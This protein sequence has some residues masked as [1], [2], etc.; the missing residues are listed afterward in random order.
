M[1]LT[2]LIENSGPEGLI[3]EHGLSLYFEYRGGNYLLDAGESGAFLVNAGHLGVD[4]SAVDA[5][6][7]S[8]GHFDHAD[9]FGGFFT[10]NDHTSVCARPG[11]KDCGYHGERYIGVNP[12]LLTRR[13]KRFDLAD[14]PR[15]IAPGLHLIPDSV[16]H[17]QSVVAETERGLVV[18]NCC[19]HAGVDKI[20]ADIMERFPGQRIRAI[21]GGFH[22]MG[23]EG[24]SSLGKTEDEVRTLARRLVDELG[25]EAVYTGHCTGTPAFALLRETCPGRFHPL[26]TGLQL[27]F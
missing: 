26:T 10:V 23:K 13:A 7:L 15:E 25:V 6:F 17:E 16:D 1:K 22:L 14:G 24:P 9:G 2:V 5:A 21:V 11:I 8:H 20:A 19:C 18:M 12:G 3:H 27:H 4:L